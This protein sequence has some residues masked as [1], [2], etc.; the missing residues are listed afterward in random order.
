MKMFTSL[1]G[2]K[3]SPT[4]FAVTLWVPLTI[5]YVSPTAVLVSLRNSV[6]T[7]ISGTLADCEYQVPE[8][9]ARPDQDGCRR[10]R[11]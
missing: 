6:L 3:T 9:S 2:A 11:R 1:P 7:S 5:V 8:I 4:I 10:R